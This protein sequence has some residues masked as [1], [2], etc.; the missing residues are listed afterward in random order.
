LNVF[1]CSS[2][3]CSSA[4]SVCIVMCGS[5]CLINQRAPN[6]HSRRLINARV[7]IC[8]FVVFSIFIHL[9]INKRPMA[10]WTAGYLIRTVIDFEYLLSTIPAY[11]IWRFKLREIMFFSPFGILLFPCLYQ[12]IC[13]FSVHVHYLSTSNL[14]LSKSYFSVMFSKVSIP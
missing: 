6:S 8:F 5:S 9:L 7:S 3:L 1:V 10:E 11:S 14:Y 13:Y 4:F 2:F 12:F